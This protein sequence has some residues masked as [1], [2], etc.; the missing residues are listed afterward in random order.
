VL[1]YNNFECIRGFS[2]IFDR[3]MIYIFSIPSPFTYINLNLNF[4]MENSIYFAIHINNYLGGYS[5][6]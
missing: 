6:G 2:N 5:S 3:E 1:E 4:Y